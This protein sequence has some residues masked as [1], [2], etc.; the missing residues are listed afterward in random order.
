MYLCHK[1]SRTCFMSRMRAHVA[2][3]LSS[4]QTSVHNMLLFWR[5][6]VCFALIC[7]FVF[8]HARAFC[9]PPP[10]STTEA[11]ASIHMYFWTEPLFLARA[12]RARVAE[13][14]A[15][16]TDVC[17][18]A[19]T[20]PPRGGGFQ[21]AARL[22]GESACLTALF[23]ESGKLSARDSGGARA[24]L[25]RERQKQNREKKIKSPKKNE[26]R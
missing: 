6:C 26:F 12:A 20:S 15:A 2:A 17:A 18:G 16:K 11:R 8:S 19:V 24:T 1:N 22:F 21:G 9:C 3:G 10:T 13:A 14:A 5:A 25:S 7:L 4:F 23:R